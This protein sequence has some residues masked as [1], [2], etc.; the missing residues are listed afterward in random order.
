MC[1]QATLTCVRS[2]TQTS[3][4]YRLWPEPVKR[5]RWGGG[6][7]VTM[8]VPSH[9][10]LGSSL[11]GR[12]C[13]GGAGLWGSVPPSYQREEAGGGCARTTSGPA[14]LSILGRFFPGADRPRFPWELERTGRM[15]RLARSSLHQCKENNT[16]HLLWLLGGCWELST[17]G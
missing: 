8:G 3:F 7:C 16:F 12:H 6:R 2:Q 17:R 10:G 1:P 13:L 9:P 5:S 11:A 4:L 15:A 14:L